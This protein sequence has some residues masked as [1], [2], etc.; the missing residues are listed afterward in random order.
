MV[1]YNLQLKLNLIH[2]RNSSKWKKNGPI[3][4]PD[5]EQIFPRSGKGRMKDPKEHLCWG[6]TRGKEPNSDAFWLG[7]SEPRSWNRSRSLDFLAVEEELG[8]LTAELN[9]ME[10]G[11]ANSS[12]ICGAIP[13]E[14]GNCALWKKKIHEVWIWGRPGKKEYPGHKSEE[15]ALSSPP[16]LL[17]CCWDSEIPTLYYGT[18]RA[19][20]PQTHNLWA[21]MLC[22]LQPWIKFLA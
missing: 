14:Q 1:R 16:P 9:T 15:I 5:G 11:R 19:R 20:V 12:N 4:S 17:R 18:W 3:L 10:K 7:A 22:D 6:A 21:Q 2:T 13:W 8:P